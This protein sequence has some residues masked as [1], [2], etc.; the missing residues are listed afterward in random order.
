MEDARG[1]VSGG[2]IASAMNVGGRQ[3]PWMGNCERET[4]CQP[5]S[6]CKQRALR[7]LA[8]MHS[9]TCCD[10]GWQGVAARRDSAAP[11]PRPGAERRQRPWRL[12]ARMQRPPSRRAPRRLASQMAASEDP[13]DVRAAMGDKYYI[14]PKG[15]R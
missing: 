8:C 12:Q 10:G 1:G 11:A 15:E 5:I 13:A 3:T 4:V 6:H 9:C 2:T 7:E 14:C